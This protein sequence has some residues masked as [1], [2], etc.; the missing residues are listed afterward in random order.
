[1]VPVSGADLLAK[2]V[3]A[4][5]LQ[6]LAMHLAAILIM[7]K[8]LPQGAVLLMKGVIP[9]DLLVVLPAA[10]MLLVGVSIVR[11]HLA[12]AL[13]DHVLVTVAIL[14][15]AVALEVLGADLTGADQEAIDA[16]RKLITL[17]NLVSSTVQLL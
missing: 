11:L 6:E 8:V 17:M 13:M 7:T 3:D 9:H 10:A 15:E 14:V 12:A 5:V 1:M 16:D 4:Q 2:V